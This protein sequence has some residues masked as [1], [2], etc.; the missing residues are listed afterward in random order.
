MPRRPL[1][2]F[3]VFIFVGLF[4]ATSQATTFYLTAGADPSV[5]ANWGTSTDGTGTHPSDF[6]TAGQVFEFQNGQSATLGANWTVQ[7]SGSKIVLDTGATLDAGTNTVANGTS[8]GTFEM[9]SGATFKTAGAYGGLRFGTVDAASTFEVDGSVTNLNGNTYGNFIWNSSGTTTP[10]DFTTGGSFRIEQST[11]RLLAASGTTAH[12]WNLGTDLNIDSGATLNLGAGANAAG[13]INIG[14]GL[15]NSGTIQKTSA[16]GTATI[17]FN[18]TGSSNVTWGT[19]N[20]GNFNVN[21]SAATKTITMA[22][23]LNNGTGTV[24]VTG[25]LNLGN[26]S[27]LN[28]TGTITVNSGGTLSITATTGTDHVNDT[29]LIDVIGGTFSLGAN[30]ET[31]GNIVLEAGGNITS[32]GGTLTGGNYDVRSGTISANLAGNGVTLFKS[33]SGGLSLTGT[34]SYSGG[35]TINGGDVTFNNSSALGSGAVNF[36]PNGLDSMSLMSTTTVSL[37]N[38]IT[39][40]DLSATMG[41]TATLGSF[42]LAAVGTN[43]YTGTIALNNTLNIK[44]SSPTSNAL[45]FSGIISGAGGLIIN[46]GGTISPGAV[47]FTG[48]NTYLGT[49]LVNAGTLLV[50]GNQ[51]AATGTVTVNSS[52]TL[53]GS[54]TIGGAVTV[55]SGGHLAPGESTGILHTGALTLS[56]GSFF[57][58]EI[59]GAIAGSNYDEVIS[60]GAINLA[61]STLTLTVGG[62]L[63]MGEKF[64]ILENSSALPN[65]VGTFTNGATISAGGYTFLIQYADSGD[66]GLTLNDIS[67]EVTAVPEP[68][69][70]VAGTLALL[71]V[72][73]AQRKR[74]ASKT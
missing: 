58:V 66:G 3:F 6:T 68:S 36:G 15:S 44:S 64:F 67:L 47:K 33:S 20:S 21:V 31:T 50:N 7:G 57:N 32:I 40:N 74:F 37:S 12:T 27:K 56:S 65:G 16:N 70:W 9:A 24:G 41:R 72:G 28:G 14:G 10:S 35:T 18:G 53:G 54:G 11:V 63:T 62:T 19:N 29:A 49:T 1:H 45:T 5:A 48:D 60:S 52:G 39:I 38:N 46:P 51:S 13:T 8:T 30:N 22:D 69:T 25:T 17:N 34:N 73:Y 55:N 26:G 61:G 59:N 42:A 23:S 4:A 2:I 43:A 71:A